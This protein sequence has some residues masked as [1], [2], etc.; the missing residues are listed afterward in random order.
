[1]SV[2]IKTVAFADETK[3]LA[4][5]N[6]HWA[7]TI[8]AGTSW[9]RIRVGCRV[10]LDDTGANRTGTPRLYMGM[11]SAPSAGLTNGPLNA[12]T[13]HFVGTM[14][15]DSTWTRLPGGG[16]GPSYQ[17]SGQTLGK[18]VAGTRTMGG[19]S[20]DQRFSFD[21]STPYRMI[22]LCEIEKGSPNFTITSHSNPIPPVD[23][24]LVL[25]ERCLESSSFAGAMSLLSGYT[26][27]S[28]TIAVDES[29]DGF[30]NAVCLGWSLTTSKLNVGEILYAIYE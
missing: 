1:M 21:D 5:G 25:L 2:E 10:T 6:A 16:G 19:A 20:L 13:S 24:S 30:L 12:G 28:T 23:H 3:R 26:A 29:S 18:K 22:L 8:T 27:S 17:A 15:D 7:A 4:L 14:P 11:L 9:N